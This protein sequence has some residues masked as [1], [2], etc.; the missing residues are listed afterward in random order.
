VSVSLC[1]T[2]F[3]SLKVRLRNDVHLSNDIRL[4][5]RALEIG[6]LMLAGV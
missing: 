4:R 3:C 1:L 6:L 5:N 2:C